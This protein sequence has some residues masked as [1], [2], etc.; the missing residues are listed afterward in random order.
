MKIQLISFRGCPN[1]ANA[2]RALQQALASLDL[3]ETFE[4]VDSAA[5]DTP[6][7]LRFWGSPTVLVNG[8]DVAG[9]TPSGASCRMYPPSEF[10]GA[11][12]LAMIVR[13][14]RGT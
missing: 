4:E 13:R 3:E 1:V 2:R 11:P 14:L 7:D 10:P 8:V 6:D 9:G 12:P 5:H